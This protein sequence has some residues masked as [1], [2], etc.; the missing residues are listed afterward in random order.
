MKT[1]VINKKLLLSYHLDD[2]C[3]SFETDADRKNFVEEH[4]EEVKSKAFCSPCLC[5]VMNS[6]LRDS[7]ATG[8]NKIDPSC[9][10][11]SSLFDH[12][13]SQK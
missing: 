6:H 3:N 10:S 13:I 7:Y 8:L 5:E 11:G 4:L 9:T 12:H 2:C 1:S